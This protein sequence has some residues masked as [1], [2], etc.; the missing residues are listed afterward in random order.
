MLKQKLIGAQVLAVTNDGITVLINEKEFFL[1]IHTDDGDCCG[2]AYAQ[3]T[4]L[5]D[6]LKVYHE[7]TTNNP[8]IT[9]IKAV[10]SG[11]G[12]SETVEI[13]FFGESK[14]LFEIS[15]EAGSGSGWNYG[16]TVSIVCSKLDLDEEIVG[17]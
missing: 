1:E 10:H 8:V 9:D 6:T 15:G 5:S 3:I 4:A 16:A 13:T 14:E 17:Y 7:D 12:S 2:F 11:D